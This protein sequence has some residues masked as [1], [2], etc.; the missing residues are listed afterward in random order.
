[1]TSNDVSTNTSLTGRTWVAFGPNGAL[2]SIHQTEGGYSYKL[3]DEHDQ[4]GLYSSLDGA[5]GALMA[6]LP[7]GSERPEFREH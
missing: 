3:L 4:R 7:S 5:K 6:S 1:M 2:G